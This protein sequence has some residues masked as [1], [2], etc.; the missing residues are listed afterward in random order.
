MKEMI[1]R[2][3]KLDYKIKWVESQ[4]SIEW[5]QSTVQNKIN[6]CSLKKY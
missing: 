1:N 3:N 6:N 4:I 2:A 5:I